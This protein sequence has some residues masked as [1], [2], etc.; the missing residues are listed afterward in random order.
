MFSAKDKQET[1]KT[2]TCNYVWFTKQ[3]AINIQQQK[4][5]KKRYALE[6]QKHPKTIQHIHLL[7]T[8]GDRSDGKT[9]PSY[10]R[11]STVHE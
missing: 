3:K 4:S 9:P 5:W 8:S 1:N 2:S 7:S 10:L 6:R 11:K